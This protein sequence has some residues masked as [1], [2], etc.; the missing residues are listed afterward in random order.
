[1]TT[2]SQVPTSSELRSYMAKVALRWSPLL[3]AT[4]ALGL[5]VALAPP[6]TS[7]TSSQA[8]GRAGGGYAAGSAGH[9]GRH[10]RAGKLGSGSGAA[11]AYGGGSSTGTGGT[12]GGS[13]QA[14]GA[15]GLGGTATSALGSGGSGPSCSGGSKQF[16]WSV[17]APPCVPP[18]HGSNGGD[19]GHGVTGGTI[20]VS[21]A[22]P[23]AAEEE[24]VNGF[25]GTAAIDTQQFINDMN[26]YIHFFNHQFELYGRKVVLHPFTAQGSYLAEDQGQD[27]AG[28]Q[29]DA[30]TAAD[31]PAFADLTFPL[32]ASQYYEQDLAAEH[33][34][35]TAGIGM[36]LSWYEQYAPYEVSYVP[37]GTAAAYGFANAICA[38]MADMP[39]IF[40]PQYSNT[41]RKFGLIVPDT[42]PYIRVEDDIVNQLQRACGLKLTVIE[43]YGLGDVQGY[44]TEAAG[45]M[46]KMKALG[47]T[48]VVCGCDPIF[49][50][51]ASQAAAQQDYYPEWVAIGWG[52]PTTRDYNQ[53]EWSHAI[54]QEGQ[55]PVNQ[56]T[57]AYKVYEMASGGK[58]PE[59]VYYEVAYYML[60]SF[61]DGLQLAGPDLNATTFLHGW[62]SMPETPVGQDGIWEGGP[63]AYSLAD[64]VTG[65]GWWDPTAT[66]NFDGKQGAWE[67]CGNGRLYYYTAPGGWGTPHTQFNCF[68]R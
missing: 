20:N 25:A 39:A 52:D 38:R 33:V 1:L 67:N 58:P 12:A 13:R 29:A 18:F 15:A 5:V 47:V 48:T 7:T 17:Y 50:I 45:Y 51:M 56:D 34:I 9:R 46:A 2:S 19:T 30:Q 11:G 22:E 27:L 61:Y 64:V 32:F 53:G 43:Q 10:V 26:V 49:P 4:A 28:A 41:T 63:Q 23:S 6:I 36:P 14:F 62:M 57:E 60:L 68:G 37:T 54:S 55:Y 66:S 8:L 44:T 3:A 21:F 35:G 40:S 42:P 24:V 65:M 16:S 59:E 31:I